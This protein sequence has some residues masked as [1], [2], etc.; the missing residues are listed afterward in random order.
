MAPEHQYLLVLQSLR[1][2]VSLGHLIHH[3]P[4]PVSPDAWS[5]NAASNM[6]SEQVTPRRRESGVHIFQG[7]PWLTTWTPWPETELVSSYS[8]QT[9]ARGPSVPL[10]S[11]LTGAA[12]CHS[13]F[14]LIDCEIKHMDLQKKRLPFVSWLRSLI[15]APKDP[16]ACF[17]LLRPLQF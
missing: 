3:V 2:L 13:Y 5:E 14:T 17:M 1:L 15:T 12:W 6:C 9:R 7:E 11:H 16:A 4:F 8:E 10:H